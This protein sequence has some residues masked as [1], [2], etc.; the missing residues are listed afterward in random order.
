MNKN[1]SQKKISGW[2]GYPVQKAKVVYPE[3]VDQILIEVKKSNLIA[4]GNGRAYGD[5][6]INE[7]NTISMKYLN[8]IISFG[9]T[10]LKSPPIFA[11]ISPKYDPYS[12][13]RYSQLHSCRCSSFSPY[14]SFF[15]ETSQVF[16]V[17]L[18]TRN[19]VTTFFDQK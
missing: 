8:H 17:S 11:D 6:S 14:K 4:R 19:I 3:N 9:N 16:K 1:S 2:G 7:K 5:S 12:I 18:V 15:D 10:I 13:Y